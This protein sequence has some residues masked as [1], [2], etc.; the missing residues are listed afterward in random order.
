[1]AQGWQPA[2]HRWPP[3]IHH[4]QAAALAGTSCRWAAGG[5][6]ERLSRHTHTAYT[7]LV[8]GWCVAL[9]LVL[10]SVGSHTRLYPLGA[11]GRTLVDDA[12]GRATSLAQIE[13]NAQ[14]AHRAQQAA[15]RQAEQGTQA[16]EQQQGQ[17]Q[18]K[19]AEAVRQAIAAAGGAG[20]K[21]G[22]AAGGKARLPPRMSGVYMGCLEN[23]GGF[24]PIRDQTSKWCARA[25]EG[26]EG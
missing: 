19:V 15:R 4:D 25:A 5:W 23:K 22:G 3:A 20:S 16:D 11:A 17:Q 24:F 14:A 12:E 18:G 10:T 1:M 26:C 21:A 8:V 13:Q 2:A 6:W 7:Q 9:E